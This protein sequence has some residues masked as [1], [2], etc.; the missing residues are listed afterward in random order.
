METTR[1]NST[2]PP[3]LLLHTASELFPK[4]QYTL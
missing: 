3:M 4:S 1:L 2:Q